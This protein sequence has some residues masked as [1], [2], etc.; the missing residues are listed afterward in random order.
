MIKKLVMTG[1]G[2]GY[3]PFASGTFGSAGAIVIGLAAWALLI[4]GGH[5]RLL[6]ATWVLLTLVASA[7]CVWGGRWAAEYYA[8]RSRKP[9][10]PGQ[11]VVDEFAGQWM[12]MI[13]LPLPDFDRLGMVA[14]V[15][16]TQF[17]LFRLF[18]VLKPPP[19]HQLERLPHG[20]GILMDDLAAGVYAN[21]IGQVVFRVVLG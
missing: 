7:G 14:A 5:V 21:I 17:F 16:A 2:L 18:D 12:A 20:W 11:V 13:A 10:D 9:G 1:F 15:F 4:P 8:S 6:D 19:A 3:A